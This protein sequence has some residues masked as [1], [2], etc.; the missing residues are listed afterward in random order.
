M[1]FLSAKL[2]S[3]EIAN[4]NIRGMACTYME[5]MKLVGFMV[6][7]AAAI[8]IS[9]YIIALAN[10][11][12]ILLYAGVML[13]A[14]ESPNF[15]VVQGREDEACRV[16]QRIRG[17]KVNVK[18]EVAIIKN[19]NKRSD[20]TSGFAAI[21]K[22]DVLKRVAALMVLIL[23]RGLCGCE[24]MTVHSTRLML[25]ASVPLD[26]S[27]GALIVNAA[28]VL[29]ALFLNLLVDCLGR[30]RS[31]LVSLTVVMLG[32]IVLGCYCHFWLEV[33]LPA[34]DVHLLSP[35]DNNATVSYTT[36]LR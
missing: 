31:L 12:L 19:K 36:G 1:Y 21:F 30:R 27:V 23:L 9:W 16:L 3:A 25:A 11:V 15:L 26:Q 29:G 34:V 5:N 2:Y 13:A 17:P 18:E 10:A 4:I 6:V 35:L 32:Y 14:P 20:G 8:P 22:R 24:V 7:V 33:A 28:Y